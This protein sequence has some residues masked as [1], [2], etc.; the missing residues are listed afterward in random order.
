MVGGLAAGRWSTAKL[1]PD[2]EARDQVGPSEFAVHWRAPKG[3]Q[4]TVL[5]FGVWNETV[6]TAVRGGDRHAAAAGPQFQRAERDDS[7]ETGPARRV[8]GGE[9]GQQ[10]A[11]R[12][13]SRRTQAVVGSRSGGTGAAAVCGGVRWGCG[14]GGPRGGGGRGLARALARGGTP[15][16]SGRP[17]N[18][19][20]WET[21]AAEG[22]CL[23]AG[24]GKGRSVA[25]HPLGRAGEQ[26]FEPVFPAGWR[27]MRKECAESTCAGVSTVR[28]WWDPR[29]SACGRGRCRSRA[30]C[31][32]R[33]RG[34]P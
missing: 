1:P 32:G 27:R 13:H 4:T 34:P 14:A 6:M 7:A 31:A 12:L 21:D 17:G 25:R 11:D 3:N 9:A 8:A 22:V 33:R 19:R 16:G 26:K 30:A 10:P 5:R 20:S 29:W 18:R 24:G 23:A 15:G 28:A 2:G